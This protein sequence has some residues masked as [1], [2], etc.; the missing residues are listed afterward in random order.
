MNRFI[1]WLSDK[2]L[3][4]K[5]NHLVS[6]FLFYFLFILPLVIMSVLSLVS[7]YKILTKSALDRRENISFLAAA[8]IKPGANPGSFNCPVSCFR[9]SSRLGR[10][11]SRPHPRLGQ[12]SIRLRA[13]QPTPGG[14]AS[15]RIERPWACPGLRL[16]AAGRM[17]RKNSP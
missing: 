12:V 14:L 9:W 13:T 4:Q 11:V 7:H 5:G 6:H 1:K 8:P 2:L 16:L 10:A 17:S 15:A 3:N